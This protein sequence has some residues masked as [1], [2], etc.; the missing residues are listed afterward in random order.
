MK[1]GLS[2]G[3]TNNENWQQVVAG[4]GGP[5][6]NPENELVDTDGNF[7]VDTDGNFLTDIQS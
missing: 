6:V 3:I 5:P 2:F 7:L 4:G 1:L